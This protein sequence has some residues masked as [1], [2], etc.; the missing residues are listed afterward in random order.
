MSG[1]IEKVRI[2]VLRDEFSSPKV[3]K[4]IKIR[5]FEFKSKSAL[6]K[7]IWVKKVE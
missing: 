3:A 7:N 1:K 2:K 4:K 6:I 5:N